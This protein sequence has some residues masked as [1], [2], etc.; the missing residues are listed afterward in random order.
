MVYCH[1]TSFLII[2]YIVRKFVLQQ[3]VMYYQVLQSMI[4][5]ICMDRKPAPLPLALLPQLSLPEFEL[6]LSVKVKIDALCDNM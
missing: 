2:I 5:I 4:C 1:N 6:R 3:Y